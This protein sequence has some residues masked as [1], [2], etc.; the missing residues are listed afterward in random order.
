MNNKLLVKKK[1]SKKKVSVKQ[2]PR[3]EARKAPPLKKKTVS[4]LQSG[5][6]KLFFNYFIEY[7]EDNQ[8]GARILTDLSKFKVEA[9]RLQNKY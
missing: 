8:Q 2:A 4:I 6:K 9:N 3:K 1:V 5:L 7:I